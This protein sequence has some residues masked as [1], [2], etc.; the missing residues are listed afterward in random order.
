MASAD[1]MA[2]MIDRSLSRRKRWLLPEPV[3]RFGSLLWRIAPAL[4]LR[5]VRKKFADD[6]GTGNAR[7]P[8]KG[9]VT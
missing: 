1:D 5:A 6:L 9:P 2:R 3:S 4:Y 8:D 7:T